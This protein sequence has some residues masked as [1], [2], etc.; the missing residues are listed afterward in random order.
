M[1]TKVEKNPLKQVA[2]VEDAIAATLDHFD[3]VIQPLDKAAGLAIDKIV[4]DFF[5]PLI[6]RLQEAIKAV[7]AT[8]FDQSDPAANS[9]AGATLGRRAVEQIRQNPRRVVGHLQQRRMFE[10][11]AQQP[12]IVLGA[13]LEAAAPRYNFAT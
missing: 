5:H 8:A 1:V 2:R 11:P 10:Q 12:D 13:V 6:Q 3:P 7:Q 9:V 4:Q